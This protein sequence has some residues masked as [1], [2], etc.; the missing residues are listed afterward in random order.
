MI[1]KET[2]LGYVYCLAKE[3]EKMLRATLDGDTDTMERILKLT[4]DIESPILSYNHETELS[5]MV[6]LAYLSARDIYRVER[7][8]K[9]GKGFVDFI[10]YPE[11]P[12]AKTGII[13]ELKVGHS[14]EEALA[15][16]KEKIMRFVLQ[17]KKQKRFFW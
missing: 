10:F 8:E 1:T 2:S 15:Q 6:N 17:E 12:P 5:A 9:S 16:I 11:L 13:L 14:P 3:S 4:H 7:E